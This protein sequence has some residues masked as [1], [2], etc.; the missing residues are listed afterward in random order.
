MHAW[1]TEN[2]LIVHWLCGKQAPSCLRALV[3]MA[4][5][6]L[7]PCDHTGALP[8]QRTQHVACVAA[9]LAAAAFAALYMA[10]GCQAAAVEPAAASAKR[11]NEI[12]GHAEQASLQWLAHMRHKSC[13]SAT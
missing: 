12:A 6:H 5:M 11:M 1:N 10:L 3:G 4:L 8:G 7:N 2:S 13:G 9:M